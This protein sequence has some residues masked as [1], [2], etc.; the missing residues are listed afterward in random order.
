MSTNKVLLRTIEEVMNDYVPVYAPIY[1]LFMGKSQAYSEEV[2]QISFKRLNAIGD[3]RTKHLTPKDTEIRQISV[4]ESSKTFKKYFL[5]NQYQQSALQDR[6]S[7]EDVVKQVL[8]EHQKH[9]DEL[10]LLGEGTAS[11]NVVNNGLFWS[12]D[13]NWSEEASVELDTDA[14]SL[15]SLHTNVMATVAAADAIAGRKLILFYGTDI[16]SRFDGLYAA[17]NAPF[18]KVLQEVLGSNYQLG[19]IPAAIT[20]ASSHGWI[21]VNLDQVKLHYTALP[22]LKAQGVNDEKMYAWFNFMM[23]SCMLDVLADG[24]VIKQPATIEA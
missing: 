3:I 1:P 11:N 6:G 13:S 17:S 12:G 4:S 8:D 5:A 10:F 24:A 19:K 9:M 14:D 22:A 16:T 2:G 18:K 7:I 21:C 23:G 20:P 15:L